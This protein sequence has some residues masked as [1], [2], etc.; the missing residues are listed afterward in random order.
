[1]AAQGDNRRSYTPGKR[2]TIVSGPLAHPNS[3][4]DSI[5]LHAASFADDRVAS[6]DNT[7]RESEKE[8]EGRVA[9]KGGGQ[10]EEIRASASLG[11]VAD[12]AREAGVKSSLRHTSIQKKVVT[13][14]EMAVYNAR[15]SKKF[16]YKGIQLHRPV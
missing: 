8:R 6:I 14:E 4:K 10:R 5:S 3:S 2:A 12:A 1:M 7:K 13:S 11:H 15:K 9:D 16:F